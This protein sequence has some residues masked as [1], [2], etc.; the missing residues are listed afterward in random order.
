MKRTCLA[1][2]VTALLLVVTETASAQIRVGVP[3]GGGYFT[4]EGAYFSYP[5]GGPSITYGTRIGNNSFVGV[6][7]STGYGYPI[8][9]QPAY[10]YPAPV[11]YSQPMYFN[12]SPTFY[13]GG[14]HGGSRRGWG[15]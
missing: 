3:T 1:I 6:N 10:Y 5:M 11:F 13:R 15:R 12:P 8:Y 7:Y 4:R 14:F 9:V 2:A